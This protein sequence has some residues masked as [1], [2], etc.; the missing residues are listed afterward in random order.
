MH[1]GRFNGVRALIFFSAGQLN[2]GGGGAAG[3]P[4]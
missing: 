1:G 4:L 3:A 2:R